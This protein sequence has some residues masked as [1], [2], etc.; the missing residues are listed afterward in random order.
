MASQSSTLVATSRRG[1]HLS[2]RRKINTRFFIGTHKRRPPLLAPVLGQKTLPNE[3][4]SLRAIKK[5]HLMPLFL[6]RLYQTDTTCIEHVKVPF[7][8]QSLDIL[9]SLERFLGFLPHYSQSAWSSQ[10]PSSGTAQ[11]FAAWRPY[12][13]K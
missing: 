12:S 3:K 4:P 2:N 8:R 1:R 11:H 9:H 5:G 6:H 7:G 13:H 10:R